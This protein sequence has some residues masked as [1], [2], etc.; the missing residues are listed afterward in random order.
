VWGVKLSRNRGHQN[1]LLAGL[2]T[3]PEEIL[4]SIDADLQDDIIVMEQMVDE[5]YKGKD[6]VCGVRKN[7]DTDSYFKRFT[8]ELYYKLLHLMNIETEYNHADY[9]LMNRRAVEA[10]KEYKETNLFLRGIVPTIGFNMGT[11]LYDRK[12]RFKGKS[13]YP[14]KKMLSLAVNGIISFS[15][16]PLRF[17]ALFGFCVFLGSLCLIAWALWVKFISGKAIPGWASSVLPI[18]FL[19][20]VQ[21]LSIGVVGE[22]IAKIY[23]EVK[24]RPRFIIEKVVGD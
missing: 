11:V 22:Y 13:K 16:L 15:P 7:R 18:Y 12:E 21:I 3:A 19:G 1:A 23:L 9:R 4:I 5:Y 10:L 6:I 20:G 8:A 24:R 17:I 14:F 2:F